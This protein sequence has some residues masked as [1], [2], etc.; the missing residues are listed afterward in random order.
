MSKT[1]PMFQDRAGLER[2]VLFS[3]AVM[4]IAITLL[5]L[6]LRAPD[7]PHGLVRALLALWP[8]YLSYLFSFFII[9]SY[10]LSHHRLFRPIVR[11]DDRLA[12]LNLGF[13]FFIAL[14]PFST[15][16]IALTLTGRAAVVV[17]SLNILPL[18]LISTA[19]GRHA[20]K[21]NRLLD[22]ACDPAEVRRHLDFSRRGLVVFLIC[23][24]VSVAF[25]A[26]FLP[27]WVLGFLSRSLG[28]RLWKVRW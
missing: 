1:F 22:P 7:S 21:D 3:D 14:I 16:L 26:A 17:Y 12:V 5:V 11:Y 28:R 10:W 13:L 4:A 19:L 27:V 24:T 15:K 9:G 23:L 25:P 2:I 20:Y 18:G 8:S 6:D